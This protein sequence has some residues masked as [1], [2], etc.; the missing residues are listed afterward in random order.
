MESLQRQRMVRPLGRRVPRL[1]AV[2]GTLFATVIGGCGGST[3]PPASTSTSSTT[4]TR[5]TP[6]S[7]TSTSSSQKLVSCGTK[8]AAAS[9]PTQISGLFSANS[10]WN[11]PDVAQQP[12][13]DQVPAQELAQE[14]QSEIKQGI[15]PWIETNTDSTPV[16]VV[17]AD[18]K[19]RLGAA[20]RD[21]SLREDAEQGV[22]TRAAACRCSSGSRPGRAPDPDP[23]IN[24]LDVG[25]LE[26][27]QGRRRVARRLGRRYARPLVESGVLHGRR[28]GPAPD[29]TGD[30]PL[31][32]CQSSPAR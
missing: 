26:A 23:A 4:T 25:V 16:Y 10:V 9:E 28:R 21:P 22:R 17:G 27:A 2:I 20:R 5:S 31:R 6:A 30:Q 29:P 18:Q 24:Q 13:G 32:V 3:P 19:L 8:D 1:T 14:A 11:R 7:G 15:G 12:M